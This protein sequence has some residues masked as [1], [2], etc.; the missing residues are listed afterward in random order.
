M[1]SADPD[2][3]VKV[4]DMAERQSMT[5]Q[6]IAVHFGTTRNAVISLGRR[7]RPKIKWNPGNCARGF[8]AYNERVKKGE[9]PHPLRI[10]ADLVRR[11]RD[12]LRAEAQRSEA[13]ETVKV[14]SHRGGDCGGDTLSTQYMRLKAKVEGETPPAVGVR[15]SVML[16]HNLA[17]RCCWAG[18]DEPPMASGRPYCAAHHL[19]SGALMTAKPMTGARSK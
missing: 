9:I 11:E 12:R 16:R 18:C 13:R 1:S 4:R 2:L 14:R 3:V 7:I 5:A 6:E 10:K 8:K 17:P 15:P 19:Q